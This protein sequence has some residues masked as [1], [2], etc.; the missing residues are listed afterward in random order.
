MYTGSTLYEKVKAEN[1][2]MRAFFWTAGG[3]PIAE[4]IDLTDTF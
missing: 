1:G 4:D 2:S 3:E